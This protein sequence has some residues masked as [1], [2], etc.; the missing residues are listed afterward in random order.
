MR[1]KWLIFLA[2]CVCLAI[3]AFW[4]FLEWWTARATGSRAG[5]FLGTQ[6]DPWDTQW[7]MFWARVGALTAQLTLS[8]AHDRHLAPLLEG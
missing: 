1:G 7:D 2:T 6:G 3:S 8:R 4:E 5:A